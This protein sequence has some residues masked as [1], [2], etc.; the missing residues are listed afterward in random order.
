M[1]TH[2]RSRES[3]CSVRKMP[4]K[5]QH[6]KAIALH[7]EDKKIAEE[8]EYRGGVRMACGNLGCCYESAALRV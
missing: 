8:V 1:A 6:A 7:Q 4:S 2:A 3:T 5:V